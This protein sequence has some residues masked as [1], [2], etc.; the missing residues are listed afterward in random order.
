MSP[1]KYDL[2]RRAELAEATRRRIVE[3]TFDL[4]GEKGITATTYKDIAERA[5]VSLA[6]VYRHFPRYDDVVMACGALSLSRMPVRDAAALQGVDDL[7][8]ATY[9]LYDW[10]PGMLAHLREEV[11][12][13]PVLADFIAGAEELVESYVRAALPDLDD[14][15]VVTVIAL[16]D[17]GVHRSLT[18]SG[19]SPAAAR[20]RTAGVIRKA[21]A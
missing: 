4:H 13:V 1:R 7:V 16:L 5:D 12:K 11:R 6:T 20:E 21:I 9:D 10:S 17:E 19:L 18:A 15:D 14:D 8:D 2:G 3:A